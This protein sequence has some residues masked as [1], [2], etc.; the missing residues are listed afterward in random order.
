MALGI[1]NRWAQDIDGQSNLYLHYVHLESHQSWPTK[2]QNWGITSERWHTDILE[3]PTCV[4]SRLL[5]KFTNYI[6]G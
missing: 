4:E 1:R 3:E 2:R 6:S 5:I